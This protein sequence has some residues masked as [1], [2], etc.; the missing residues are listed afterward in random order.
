MKT[1][2]IAVYDSDEEDCETTAQA[3][4]EH[5]DRQGE[6]ATVRRFTQGEDFVRDFRDNHY[7]MAFLAMNRVPDLE[8]ARSAGQLDLTCPLFFVSDVPDYGLEGYRLSVYDYI[9][10]PVTHTRVREAVSRVGSA[11][12]EGRGRARYG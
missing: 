12:A 10:K 6:E 11:F 2:K 4:R 9:L 1:K 3:I 7:D 5:Y 8:I